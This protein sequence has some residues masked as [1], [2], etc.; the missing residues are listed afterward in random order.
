MNVE[1]RPPARPLTAV[2]GTFL[3]SAVFATALWALS[4]NFI[5]LLDRIGL[6]SRAD[7][8]AGN[9]PYGDQESFC[10]ISLAKAVLQ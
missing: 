8:A 4:R 7:D 1:L 10:K 5:P 2:F 9:L 3:E 6:T